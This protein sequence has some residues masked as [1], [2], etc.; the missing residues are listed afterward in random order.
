MIISARL[1]EG[2]EDGSLATDLNVEIVLYDVAAAPP[3][4]GGAAWD[5]LI[6]QRESLVLPTL[7]RELSSFSL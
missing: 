3:T 6:A 7:D 1:T 2:L 5:D 4:P